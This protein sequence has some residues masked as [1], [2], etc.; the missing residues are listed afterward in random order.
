MGPIGRVPCNFGE[1]GD[2]VYFGPVQLLRLAII[3]AGV[4]AFHGLRGSA[5]PVLTA[6][7]FVNARWQF[8]T[9][10]RIHTP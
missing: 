6:T 7:G 5:S 4:N 3:F 2:Q 9:P 1:R 8:S 10:H